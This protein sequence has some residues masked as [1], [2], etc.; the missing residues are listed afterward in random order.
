MSVTV[1]PKEPRLAATP[2]SQ[3]STSQA[4]PRAAD[5]DK[6]TQEDKVCALGGLIGLLLLSAGGVNEGGQMIQQ[7]CTGRPP[8]GLEPAQ[9]GVPVRGGRPRADK[10]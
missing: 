6:L 5:S 10:P 3:G 1:G 9:G 7:S 2:A 8:A 4:E